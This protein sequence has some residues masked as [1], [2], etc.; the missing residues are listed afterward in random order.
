MTRLSCPSS[1]TLSRAA[2]RALAPRS[3]QVACLLI[4]LALGVV[5]CSGASNRGVAD[6]EKASAAEHDL[7][8][9]ALLKGNFRTALVHAEKAI[10]L[11]DSNASAQL[12]VA[13]IYLGFCATSPDECRLS[14]A[15]RHAQAALKLKGDLRDA[16]NTL[17]VVLIQRRQYDRAIEVLQPLTEDILYNTPEL[18]W[19]N[20]GLAQ[21]EK[22]DT[23]KAI[24]A[25]KRAVA[26]QP[27][28]CVGNFRLARAYEKR[29]ELRLAQ[30][31]LD[32]TVNTDY[33]QCQ[34]ADAYEARARILDQLG[35]KSE[36]HA[37]LERCTKAGQGTPAG[38]RCAS[39]LGQPP[40]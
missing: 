17:G 6:P 27:A 20:L 16:R 3:R 35:E 10:E 33:P 7:A 24:V 34:F 23:D 19:G 40:P 29:G 11:D 25:L 32:A 13:N 26:L 21:L 37:D 39:S 1:S 4:G 31:A 28:F 38:Q 8:I 22:G 12:L 18:A 15:E 5:G 14:E 2:L 36:A 9:D 30:R